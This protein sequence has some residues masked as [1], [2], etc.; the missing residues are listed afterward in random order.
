[1]SLIAVVKI[2]RAWDILTARRTQICSPKHAESQEMV[3][4]N[5]RTRKVKVVT[6]GTSK[7]Y[8]IRRLCNR[9]SCRWAETGEVHRK[10]GMRESEF[11][12][13]FLFACI[14]WTVKPECNL[15]W[16]GSRRI[17]AGWITIIHWTP[18]TASLTIQEG[19]T[20]IIQRSIY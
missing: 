8:R 12:D 20:V 5:P 4:K 6:K 11:F 19:T 18:T 2:Y 7:K 9:N 13:I 1:M 3:L 17:R 15:C 16:M 14:G 10:H